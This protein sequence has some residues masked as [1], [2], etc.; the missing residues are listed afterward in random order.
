MKTT[1][2]K[3]S[4][5]RLDPNSDRYRICP[6]PECKKPHMVSH[7]GKDYCCDKCAD[8]DY[9][10]KRRLDNHAV[11]MMTMGGSVNQIANKQVEERKESLPTN[12]A[13]TK[14]LNEEQWQEAM[15][16][17]L[18]ILHDLELDPIDGTCFWINDFVEKGFNFDA[19]S[20]VGLLH[21]YPRNKNGSYLIFQ[22]YQM[23][24]LENDSILIMN[25]NNLNPRNYGE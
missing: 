23:F 21:N 10:R 19:H 8:D 14:S 24:C 1:T 11:S 17:N 7:R 13:P 22:N 4:V 20:T 15:K 18:G 2:E 25:T 12:L 16:I 9:N 6:N 5:Y 3:K